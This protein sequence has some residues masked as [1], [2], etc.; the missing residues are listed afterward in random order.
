MDFDNLFK[1]DDGT[2]LRFFVEAV[3]NNFLS[4]KANRPIFDSVLFVSVIAA[5]SAGSSPTFELERTFHE[6][7][8]ME[9]RINK[10]KYALYKPQIEAFKRNEESPELRGTPVDQW[11]AL[12]KPQAAELKALRIFTVE[13]LASLPDEK[14]QSVGMGA[15]EL[16][17]RAKAF[18]VAAEGGADTSALAGENERLRGDVARLSG[19]VAD[20]SARLTAA[21]GGA[22]QGQGAAAPEA[23]PAAED[24]AK[25]GKAAKN[26]SII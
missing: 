2:A 3:Q 7:A 23:K 25:A 17:E 26:E 13:A 6:S 20:M 16:R 8:K 22:Q 21:L 19:E 5:G 24:G 9:P 15:L 14:L 11:T 1:A 4:E 10:E 12:S 18:L